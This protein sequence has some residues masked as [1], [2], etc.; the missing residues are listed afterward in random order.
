MSERHL[1]ALRA[2]HH[3]QLLQGGQD[4]FPEMI[5]AVDQSRHEVRVETYIFNAD[6]SGELVA[7]ALVRAARRGV[8]VYLVVDGVGTPA[9]SEDMAGR[10]NQAGVK[11][12]IYKP[13]GWLGLLIPNRWRRMHRKLCVVDGQMAF[14]G[15]INVLD[16]W[17]DPNHGRLDAPRFDFAVRV[18]GPLVRAAHEVMV[19]FWW[20][21]QA[22]KSVK[23]VDLSAAWHDLEEAVK[24]SRL[25]R[26]DTGDGSVAP[27]SDSAGAR[28]ALLLRDNLRNRSRI[29]RAYRKAISD[30]R[31]EIIIANAYFIPGHKLRKALVHAARRGVKVRLLLQGRYE[32]FMQ[33]HAVRLVYGALLSAGIEIHEYS[34]SFLHAKVAVIDGHWSTV[35][36]SN[37]DPLSLL[38]AREANVVLEDTRFARDLRERL[39]HAM[40]HEGRRVDPASFANRPWHQ[41]LL[42]W[43]AFGLMRLAV[44]LSGNRY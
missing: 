5:R 25:D 15:G 40:E 34:P 14:C 13:L 4:L 12:R 31:E 2:A 23:Q 36:S 19:L 9:L 18:S 10:F 3:V 26:A 44:F 27:P 32:Y 21:L 33:F 1:P 16:D 22:A 24:Q 6:P 42:D 30:A 11:W 39:V 8:A 29:E 17:Y 41:H 35:G 43:V 37:L 20:R 7:A 38:L 28:A